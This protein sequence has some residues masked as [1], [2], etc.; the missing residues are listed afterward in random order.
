MYNFHEILLTFDDGYA[1]HAAVVMESTVRKSKSKLGFFI[2]HYDISQATQNILRRHFDC[3]IESMDFYEV[4]KNMVL[5]MVKG[6]SNH[7]WGAT[8]LRL[9][10]PSTRV[11]TQLCIAD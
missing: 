2:I 6:V 11:S 7:I 9:F 4:D 1:P 10:A 5:D 3:R 8:W